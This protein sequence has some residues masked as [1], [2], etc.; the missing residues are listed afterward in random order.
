MTIYSKK[1]LVHWADNIFNIHKKFPEFEQKKK[2]FM[3]EAIGNNQTSNSPSHNNFDTNISTR[4][5]IDESAAQRWIDFLLENINEKI[6]WT[7]IE[8]G[9]FHSKFWL[10]LNTNI[11]LLDDENLLNFNHQASDISVA[12]HTHDYDT[13]S[14]IIHHLL[15][16]CD[17]LRVYLGEPTVNEKQQHLATFLAEHDIEKIVFYSDC[18]LN[19]DLKQATYQTQICWFMDTVNYYAEYTWCKQLLDLLKYHYDKP[20]KFDALLGQQKPHRDYVFNRCQNDKNFI[21]TYFKKHSDSH[22]GTW[23][24]WANPSEIPGQLNADR[25]LINGEPARYSSVIPV[26]IYNQSYYSIVCETTFFNEYS[27]YTEK[28]AKPILALRPFVA[29]NG[30]HWLKNLRRLGFM[31]FGDVIDESYD[32]ISDHAERWDAAWQ[33][34]E[35]LC[36]LDPETVMTKLNPV[37]QHNRRHFLTTDWWSSARNQII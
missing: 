1:T 25:F 22:L 20:Y 8:N 28:T 23:P 5:W 7:K 9:N 11:Q 36:D 24:D 15:P 37:L 27:F 31:T 2:K 14:Q 6:V 29:F 34:V 3:L 21:T 30:Q 10:N 13:H 19:F 17:G 26:D 33:Q 18:I 12:F 35:L 32:D 4:H 16:K